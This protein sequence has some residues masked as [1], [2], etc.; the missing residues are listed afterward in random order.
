MKSVFGSACSWMRPQIM[1]AMPVKRSQLSRN[2]TCLY[3]GREATTGKTPAHTTAPH[4]VENTE[5]GL[6]SEGRHDRSWWR[7]SC[8]LFSE[9]F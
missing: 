5:T 6:L 7:D 2:R 1:P 4:A 9:A 3:V 8:L